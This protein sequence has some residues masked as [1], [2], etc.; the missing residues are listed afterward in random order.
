MATAIGTVTDAVTGVNPTP[1]SA[2]S[3]MEFTWTEQSVLEVRNAQGVTGCTV[4][5]TTNADTDANAV[6]DLSVT[7]A[8]GTS[9]RIGPF[10]A[11]IYRNPNTGKV[12]VALDQ[13]TSITAGVTSTPQNS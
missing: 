1:T 3:T 10:K 4:T 8:A 2:A 5:I 13:T 11:N 7:V 6:A 9:K 12:D